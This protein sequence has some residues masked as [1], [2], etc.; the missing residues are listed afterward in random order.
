MKRHPRIAPGIFYTT[1][2]LYQP[3][4]A[5]RHKI[6]WLK[7]ERQPAHAQARTG[8]DQHVEKHLPQIF[9]IQR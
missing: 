7:S 6:L 4:E 9:I 8:A 2:K 5:L 1:E 3:R